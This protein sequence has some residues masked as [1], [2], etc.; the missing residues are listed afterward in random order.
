MIL[1]FLPYHEKYCEPFAGG[2]SIF[3]SKLKV[4]YNILNDLDDELVN[5]YIHIRDYVEDIIALLKG[6]PANKEMHNFYKNEYKPANNLEKAFRWFYLNRISYS[7]IMKAQNCYFGYGEKYSMKPENWPGHLRNVSKKLQS[8]D[9][10]CLDF[11]KILKR[12]D[13]D[14]FLFIDPP[15]FNADQDKFYNICFSREDHFRLSQI[16]KETG[17]K[18]LLT[19]DDTP[20]I[21]EL[22]SWCRIAVTKEWFYNF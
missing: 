1:E 7:G 9:I 20:E 10:F 19:Y 22:Y 12:L 14:F 8:V 18:F 5:C 6:I 3:F 16:L 4:N 15:Y 11:E 17:C 21:R 13:N 2:A